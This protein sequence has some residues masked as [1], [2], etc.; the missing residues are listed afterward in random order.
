MPLLR[1]TCSPLLL[2]LLFSVGVS[3]ETVPHYLTAREAPDSL[4]ILPPPPAFD[5]VDFLRD[6]ALYDWGEAQ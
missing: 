5:S 1:Y 4:T 2:S 3:A 6:K